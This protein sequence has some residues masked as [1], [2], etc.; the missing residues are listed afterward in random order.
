[1]N[2]L[3]SGILLFSKPSEIHSNSLL[4]FWLYNGALSVQSCIELLRSV[5]NVKPVT[6]RKATMLVMVNHSGM[7]FFL[8]T[9]ITGKSI[10]VR[11]KESKR[12]ASKLDANFMP[13]MIINRQAIVF[14]PG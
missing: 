6:T 12:G 9:L 2:S 1:M 11:K 7:F 14:N 5:V 8:E 4:K 10:S 13:P 3:V